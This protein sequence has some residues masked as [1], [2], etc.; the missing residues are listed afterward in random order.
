MPKYLWTKKNFQK[1]PDEEKNMK[2]EN[3]HDIY[4]SKFKRI[5]KYYHH[6]LIDFN[7]DDIHFFRVEIKRLKAFLRLLN[8]SQ[9]N[10]RFKVPKSLRKFYHMLGSV[11][12][13]QLHQQ[14][15]IQLSRDLF[16]DPPC[17]YLQCM[18][19][20]EKLIKKKSLQL[21][22]D[23]SMKSLEKKFIENSAPEL[24]V[25]NK[26]AFVQNIQMRLAQLLAL[27]C[28]Y[29][30]TLHD[31]RKQIKDLIYNYPFLDPASISMLSPALNNAKKMDALAAILGDYHDLCLAVFFLDSINIT[32]FAGETDVLDELKAHLYL[33]KE[34]MMNEVLKSIT[35]LR[36]Q[37]QIQQ[38]AAQREL[39]AC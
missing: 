26:N 10:N 20:R 36:R 17:A 23:I 27:P 1:A 11:R 6:L 25:Q 22:N 18:H 35:P 7:N 29:D 28:F 5:R 12:S 13:L 15:T 9:T 3:R 37:F 21:T 30:E 34:N 24:T 38:S 33:R 31:L 16:L 14:N 4:H 32:G 2:T 8:S 19:D 39:L